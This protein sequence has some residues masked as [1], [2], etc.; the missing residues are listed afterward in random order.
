MDILRECFFVCGLSLSLSRSSHLNRITTTTNKHR[1]V[2]LLRNLLHSQLVSPQIIHTSR[3]ALRRVISAAFDCNV[4][5]PGLFQNSIST[6]F[7][8]FESKT[9]REIVREMWMWFNSI[10]TSQISSPSASVDTQLHVCTSI[11]TQDVLAMLTGQSKSSLSLHSQQNERG[12][13]SLQLHQAERK[14][15]RFVPPICHQV[16]RYL[17]NCNME[18]SFEV[19]KQDIIIPA[20]ER[21]QILTD[22][23]SFL[24][25]FTTTIDDALN[26][27]TRPTSSNAFVVSAAIAARRMVAR[28]TKELSLN[29]DTLSKTD[30]TQLKRLS[31]YGKKLEMTV[32]EQLE[33]MKSAS[34]PMH[35]LF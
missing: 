32:S 7:R 11:M 12:D 3:S 8:L 33:N 24:T 22:I 35:F 21:R 17:H 10:V 28:I 14:T 27:L 20:F 18:T 31:G 25:H 26:S 4:M 2:M 23:L 16:L 6:S 5:I 34:I 13:L 1:Y 19:S 9:R 15:F 29:Q 30:K